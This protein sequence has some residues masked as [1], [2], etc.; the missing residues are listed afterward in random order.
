MKRVLLFLSIVVFSI[1][2]GSQITEGFLLVP[3][4]KML[5]PAE[6]YEYYASF[7]PSIGKFYTVLTIIAALIPISLSAYCFFYKSQGLKYAIASTFFAFLF[8]GLFYVYFKGVNQQFY[9]AVFNAGQLKDALNTW[10]YLH[11][12]RVFFE[13]LSLFFLILAINVSSLKEDSNKTI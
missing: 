9:N 2:V 4:W 1:F 12:L 8:V 10:E 11:W 5:S 7:G 13:I 3:Y 6:F